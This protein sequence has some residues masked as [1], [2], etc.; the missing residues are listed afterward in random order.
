MQEFYVAATRKLDI[1]P[2]QAKKILSFFSDME[3]V[4][5]EP[6]D[7]HRAI[8]RS[9]VWKISFWDALV[10]TTAR[11]ARCRILYSEDLNHGQNYDSLIVKNPFVN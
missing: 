11:K 5:I 7:V 4:T 3:I 1:A 8:D 2:L 10:I 9:L 6:E